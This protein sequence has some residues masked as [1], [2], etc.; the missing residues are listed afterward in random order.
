MGCVTVSLWLAQ[1]R[2]VILSNVT[3][4]MSS[5]E[6]GAQ[7]LQH[8]AQSILSTF[9]KPRCGKHAHCQHKETNKKPTQEAASL[10]SS[11]IWCHQVVS[12]IPT[13]LD[14][15]KEIGEKEGG[16]DTSLD[17][18]SE[19]LQHGLFSGPRVIKP[20]KSFTFKLR[21]NVV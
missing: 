20:L 9:H 5:S 2:H 11:V 4:M 14:P 3:M 21:A 12:V 18:D 1:R 6:F 16:Q 8:L 7:H 13:L 10:F 19:L 17:A 15:G